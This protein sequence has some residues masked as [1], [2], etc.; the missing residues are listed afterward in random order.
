MS[1]NTFK[2]CFIIKETSKINKIWGFAGR[3]KSFR[4]PNLARGPYFVHSWAQFHQHS[5][6]SFYARRS[7]VRKKRQSS[8]QCRLALLGPTS[9]KAARKTLVKLTPG[10]NKRVRSI[11]TSS[12]LLMFVK[13][14][15]RQ[16][17]FHPDFTITFGFAQFTTWFPVVPEWLRTWGQVTSSVPGHLVRFDPDELESDF[18]GNS[19]KNGVAV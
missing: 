6:S 11:F 13:V 2:G 15:R 5:T 12:V 14:C 18:Y 1:F 7:R 3:I 8:W 17:S 9:I 16:I 4:M 10:L 19:S